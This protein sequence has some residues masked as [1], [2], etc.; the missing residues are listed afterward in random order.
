MASRHLF[1]PSFCSIFCLQ[2]RISP[3]DCLCSNRACRSL[4]YWTIPARIKSV[5]LGGNRNWPLY[6]FE[7]V[8]SRVVCFW[9][10]YYDCAMT[11]MTAG[12]YSSPV[13]PL[14]VVVSGHRESQQRTWLGKSI[15]N[16]ESSSLRLTWHS[17]IFCEVV[18]IYGVVRP[19]QYRPM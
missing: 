17:I 13:H 9:K 11:G 2:V 12:G 8:G 18:A 3:N 6:R 16:F 19:V 4:W 14:L 5:C 7:R 10:S 15:L 1:W